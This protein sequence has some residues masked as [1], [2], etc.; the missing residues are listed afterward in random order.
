MSTR[1]VPVVYRQRLKRLRA[2]FDANAVDAMLVHCAPDQY[3]LTGAVLEDSAVLV[4]PRAVVIVTDSRFDEQAALQAPWARRVIRTGKLAEAVGQTVTAIKAVR[5]LGLQGEHVPVSSYQ[6]QARHM[7]PVRGRP[8]VGLVSRL[9]LCKDDHEVGLIERAVAAAESAYLGT[10]KAVKPGMTESEVSAELIYRMQ[11]A[12]ASGPSFEPIVA[13]GPR[14]SLPH[15]RADARVKVRADQPI[16]FDWGAKVGGYCSDLTRMF[17]LRRIPPNIREIHAVVL[18]AQLAGIA[19]VAPGRRCG[20][21]DE[22]ARKIIAA[23]GYGK[24]FGHGLGHGLGLDV[25]E[26]PRLGPGR[27]ELLE[28]G[29]VVTVEPGIYLP[30]VGGVRIEDDVLVTRTGSR[31]LTS[32]PK[33]I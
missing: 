2:T 10:V 30:G 31:V 13:A 27:E 33:E 29:M 1:S 12:G 19:A 26:L 9:R 32:L 7:Q 14:A 5:N 15:A 3:Y 23:A 28:P 18:E 11:R 22:A 21:V 24:R 16:L 8:L 4:T 17:Y 6:D 25:H 20:D